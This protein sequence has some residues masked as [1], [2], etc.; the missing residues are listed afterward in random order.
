[1]LVFI[2]SETV[3]TF[4]IP[5]SADVE[6]FLSVQLNSNLV[7]VLRA[8]PTTPSCDAFVSTLT[9]ATTSLKVV[10]FAYNSN[11]RLAN[12]L[13]GIDKLSIHT[14]VKG[15]IHFFCDISLARQIGA[16]I[17]SVVAEIL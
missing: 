7:L 4:V 9:D 3:R 8:Q 13:V 1:M 2:D 10:T 16:N 14:L 12:Y 15:A 6:S 17:I 11:V 5:I